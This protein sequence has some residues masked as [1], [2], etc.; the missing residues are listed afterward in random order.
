MYIYMIVDQYV[1]MSIARGKVRLKLRAIVNAVMKLESFGKPCVV[2]KGS[3]P[4][5]SQRP[6]GLTARYTLLVECQLPY[7]LH[8]VTPY[9]PVLLHSLIEHP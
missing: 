1:V 6:P 3:K 8:P 9:A 7:A 5:F 4:V 2:M